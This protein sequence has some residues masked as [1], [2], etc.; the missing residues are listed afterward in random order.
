MFHAAKGKTVSLPKTFNPSTSKDSM[1]Q[2][3]FSDVAWG[4]ATPS[5]AKSAHSLMKVKF[6][7]IIEL[8]PNFVKPTCGHGKGML[9]M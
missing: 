9:P 7:G 1:H 4:K 2:T 5:Y 8:A 3:S 6:D